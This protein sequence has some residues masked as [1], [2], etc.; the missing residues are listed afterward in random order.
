MSDYS[1][2]SG[3]PKRDMRDLRDAL[4]AID[5]LVD[6]LTRQNERLMML[7]QIV[8]QL[9]GSNNGYKKD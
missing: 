2:T 5:L 9:E 1:A 4:Q 6:L 3:Y 7:E 8:K